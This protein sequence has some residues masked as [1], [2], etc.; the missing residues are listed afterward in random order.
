[1]DR[2]R[3]E[4]ARQADSVSA[5]VPDMSDDESTGESIPYD[6]APQVKQDSASKDDEDEDDEAE[7]DV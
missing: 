2:L 1:M 7:G 6:D 3:A 4:S 5:P